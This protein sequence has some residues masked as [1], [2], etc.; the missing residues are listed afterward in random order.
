MLSG[1]TEH[2][3]GRSYP[4]LR[5]PQVPCLHLGSFHF[6]LYAITKRRN[7]MRSTRT[8]ASSYCAC[9]VSQLSALPPNTFDKRTAISGEIPRFPFTSSDSVVRVTPSAAAACVIVSPNGSM[10]CRSTNPPGCGGLFI[11]MFQSPSVVIDIVDVHSI[12]IF[13]SKNHAP[14]RSNGYRPKSSKLAFQRMQPK[15]R[16]VHVR[17]SACGI[18]TRQDVAELLRVLADHAS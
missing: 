15:T 13:K 5:V 6:S 16:Q 2:R 11:A 4:F 14:V 12:L 10:H 7:L 3:L 9:C 18:E 8:C 17:G 1:R